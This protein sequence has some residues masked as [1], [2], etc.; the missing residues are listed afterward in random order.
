MARVKKAEYGLGRMTRQ[1]STPRKQVEI[2]K[3]DDKD[4]RTRVVR[5]PVFDLPTGEPM[6][7]YNMTTRRTLRGM[8]SGATRPKKMVEQNKSK[9]S[10]TETPRPLPSTPR[11]LPS[12]SPSGPRPTV[13][14]P[15]PMY[16]EMRRGGKASK[17]LGRMKTTIGNIRFAK[18]KKK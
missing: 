15:P 10:A 6:T 2:Y 18:S 5:K 9:N 4:Y 13:P 1:R 8:L 11:A 7:K 12:P 3:T 17:Q 16:K 14:K